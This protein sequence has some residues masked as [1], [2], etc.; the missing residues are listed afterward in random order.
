[1]SP[2]SIEPTAAQPG[3]DRV[4][5]GTVEPGFPGNDDGNIGPAAPAFGPAKLAGNPR[6]RR[7]AGGQS[8][9]P[10]GSGAVGGG[11]AHVTS[12]AA[13]STGAWYLE[14]GAFAIIFVSTA[15]IPSG[16]S[17]RICKIERGSRV[18]CQLNF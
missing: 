17:G 10:A 6:I 18:R 1:M 2:T 12:A 3:S 14:P 16:T 13:T 15:T 8:G 4:A 11:S 7:T 5:G 9:R